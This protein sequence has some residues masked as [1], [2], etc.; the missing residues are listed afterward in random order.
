MVF[1]NI[2]EMVELATAEAK[3][4]ANSN[5]EDAAR[6]RGELAKVDAEIT[7]FSDLMADP[8]VLAEPLAKKAL[9]RR[10]RVGG[11]AGRIARQAVSAC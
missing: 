3:I 10:A 1:D 9:L 11:Q 7:K 2:D 6:I 8:D 5:R 4:A